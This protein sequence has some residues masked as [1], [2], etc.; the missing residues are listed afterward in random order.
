MAR[1]KEAVTVML[2]EGISTRRP[3]LILSFTPSPKITRD[4]GNAI[5]AISCRMWLGV[6]L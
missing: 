1:I 4:A 6:I 3:R 2:N 5:T